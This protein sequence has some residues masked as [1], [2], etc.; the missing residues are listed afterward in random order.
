MKEAKVTL[1]VEAGAAQEESWLPAG[2]GT[3]ERTKPSAAIEEGSKERSMES[4]KTMRW[5]SR[6]QLWSSQEGGCWG[7]GD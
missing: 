7:G 4:R 3:K 6:T 2:V 1:V 5:S